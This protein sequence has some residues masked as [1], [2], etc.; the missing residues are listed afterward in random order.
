MTERNF[1]A[2]AKCRALCCQNMKFSDMSEREILQTFPNAQAILEDTTVGELVEKGEQ[3]Y[4]NINSENMPGRE[5]DVYI[6]GRCPHLSSDNS[7][8][9]HGTRPE[10]CKNFQ[11]G[12]PKC[13]KKRLR[14]GLEPVS[15]SL[16]REAKQNDSW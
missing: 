16:A 13:T 6:I 1:C 4:F 5:Y 10:A 11:I 12:S 7:C 9:V 15:K 2:E 14:S 8:S 3:V